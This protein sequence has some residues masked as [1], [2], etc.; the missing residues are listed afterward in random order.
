M[1]MYKISEDELRGL[2]YNAMA[3]EALINGGVDNWEWY[4]LE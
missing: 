3:F 2:L 1:K 4:R